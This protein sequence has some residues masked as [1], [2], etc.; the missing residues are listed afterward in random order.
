[1]LDSADMTPATAKIRALSI[2]F[3]LSIV[4]TWAAS[5]N[6]PLDRPYSLRNFEPLLLE[7]ELHRMA[8]GIAPRTFIFPRPCLS[9]VDSSQV[10]PDS[11]SGIGYSN[12]VRL[13]R[14]NL[15]FLGGYEFR[16]SHENIH[17]S[18]VGIFS[19]GTAGPVSFYLDARMTTE[20]H[21]FPHPVSYDREYVERQDAS[22]SG[23]IAYS[24]FSRY[25]SNLNYEWGW[26][27]F[28]VARDAVHWG[29]GA[30]SNLM[31]NRESVPFNQLTFSANLGPFQIQS[32]YGQLIVEGDRVFNTKPNS[33]S[34]YAHR[35]EWNATRNLLIGVS[36]QMILFNSEEPFAFIPLVPLFIAKGDGWERLNNGSIAGDLSYRFPELATI[37]SEF[38][39]DDIQ[40][41]TAL[42]NEKWGNKW[43]WM[44]G[45]HWIADR[46]FGSM[47]LIAEYSRIEPWVYTHY[48]PG[49]AQSANQGYPLGNP[50]GPNSQNLAVMSYLNRK[51]RWL[52]SLRTDLTWKGNDLGSSAT[53]EPPKDIKTKVFLDGVDKPELRIRLFASYNFKHAGAEIESQIGKS[54]D[55]RIR[56]HFLY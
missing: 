32:L 24:S 31:F 41:P 4:A 3:G 30:F 9:L 47:G 53:D 14:L 56:I 35:Y 21:E 16:H 7:K 13:I 8:A 6:Q 10:C 2:F 44:A 48:L 51:D 42:F 19:T 18:D 37:Y 29:P 40:A 20:V 34:V 36:E 54:Q 22:T 25:R 55:F 39:I 45:T 1:M 15:G 33:R 28:T 38:L 27:R 23:S 50:L 46:S 12:M 5:P 17:G 52:V 43:G 49:T 11:L 26:G